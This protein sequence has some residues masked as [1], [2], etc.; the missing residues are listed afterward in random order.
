M[1]VRQQIMVAAIEVRV[2]AKLGRIRRRYNLASPPRVQ[3]GFTAT[4]DLGSSIRSR[5]TGQRRRPAARATWL[6]VI[7][8]FWTCCAAASPGTARNVGLT[9]DL[10]AKSVGREIGDAATTAK[11]EA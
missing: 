8:Q 2:P 7:A 3:T 1:Q 11:L 5:P 4:S 10:R 6:D 9:L